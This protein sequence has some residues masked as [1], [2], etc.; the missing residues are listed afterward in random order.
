MMKEWRPLRRFLQVAT[1]ATF[2]SMFSLFLSRG[3]LSF[4]GSSGVQ[5][6]KN[7]DGL[8]GVAKQLGYINTGRTAA[9]KLTVEMVIDPLLLLPHIP[10][11]FD[12]PR[13]MPGIVVVRI[14]VNLE[15]SRDEMAK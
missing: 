1:S 6:Q 2:A 11:Q 13:P 10:K 5:W 12:G 14:G 3:F 7:A 8:T 4:S 9:K 15:I